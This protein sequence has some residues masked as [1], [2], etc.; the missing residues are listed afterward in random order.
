MVWYS[1]V[2]V[3]SGI[4]VCIKI[5]LFVFCD[6]ANS[7]LFA[8]KS[9]FWLRINI[10]DENFGIMNIPLRI[11]CVDLEIKWF[12]MFIISSDNLTKYLQ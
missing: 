8:F 4:N 9:H 12:L 10:F 11:C 2:V 7:Y 5:C 3:F 6:R 1:R